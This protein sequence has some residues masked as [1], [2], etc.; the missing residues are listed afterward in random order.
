M[1]SQA[2]TENTICHFLPFRRWACTITY[3]LHT[4]AFDAFLF[5]VRFSQISDIMVC[6]CGGRWGH[7]SCNWYTRYITV[8]IIF[9]LQNMIFEVTFIHGSRDANSGRQM[10]HVWRLTYVN[11]FPYLT[12]KIY[13]DKMP[14]KKHYLYIKERIVVDWVIVHFPS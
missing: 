12:E 14:R 5:L 10:S 8:Y 6:V 11:G 1:K 9:R 4:I 2:V 3:F 7:C 13:L